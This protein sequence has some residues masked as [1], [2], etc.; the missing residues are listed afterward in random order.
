[1]VKSREQRKARA[2]DQGVAREERRNAMKAVHIGIILL[3]LVLSISPLAEAQL[4]GQKLVEGWKAFQSREA[5][6]VG[7]Y[8]TKEAS[9]YAGYVRGVAEVISVFYDIPS[10]FI[11]E[12]SNY[13]VGKYLDQHP[14][15]WN[16]PAVKLVVAAFERRFQKL[17]TPK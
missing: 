1:M 3:T 2:D 14:E 15:R 6:M 11:A 5:G 13:L 7:Q 9:F 10:D 4:S 16:E 17:T 8:E 12:E